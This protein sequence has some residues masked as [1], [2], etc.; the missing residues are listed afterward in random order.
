MDYREKAF[1][2]KF[3]NA[4]QHLGVSHGEVI[5]L[6]MRET[7]SSYGEY[8]SLI[9]ALEI[10]AGLPCSKLADDLQGHGYLLTDGKTKAI[11]VEH[12]TGLEILYIAGS[13]A[14]LVGLIPLVL[15]IW[16]GIRNRSGR[17][18]S[19]DVQSVEI[20]RIDRTGHLIE[21]RARGLFATPAMTHLGLVSSTLTSAAEVLDGEMQHLRE[22]VKTLAA[23]VEA[24]EKGI[25]SG[26][27]QPRA[28]P[29]K[30]GGA[31]GKS[32]P[33]HKKHATE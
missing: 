29:S 9:A 23:R 15:N 4:A 7:V 21:D 25:A 11:I 1:R 16:S 28:K 2:T 24:L 5:S 12:E 6:K 22:Q 19:H 14:S 32:S 33:R 8:H 30:A 10:E 31:R 18:H 13:I 20:R 27:H 17:S 3:A 26:S